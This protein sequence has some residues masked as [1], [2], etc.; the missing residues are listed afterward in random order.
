MVDID[1]DTARQV[2][3]AVIPIAA[4]AAGFAKGPSSRRRRLA[5][6]VEMVEKLPEGSEARESLLQSIN[7]QI[8]LLHNIE[9]SATR[10][11]SGA[12]IATLMGAGC[13]YGT[14]FLFDRDTWWG[15]LAGVILAVSTLACASLTFDA[16]RLDF[17]DE[18]GNPI[19]D[20]REVDPAD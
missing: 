14:V 1:W 13:G 16:V 12:V 5:Q 19:R 10:D 18:K 6:D 11:W 7:L 9:T 15:Y 2:V 20:D 17:R 8:V 3:A 4:A